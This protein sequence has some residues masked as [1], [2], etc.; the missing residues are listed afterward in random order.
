MKLLSFCD[1]RNCLLVSKK[2]HD[3]FIEY[4]NVTDFNNELLRIVNGSF[5][6]K[7]YISTNSIKLFVKNQTSSPNLLLR[8]VCKF[9]TVTSPNNNGY[10]DAVKPL[11]ED[12]RVDPTC[13]NNYAIKESSAK[14]HS[15]LVELLLEDPRI[16]PSANNNKAIIEA[17][18]N[19][20]FS[21]V[22]LL[23]Q[24]PRVDPSY[25]K[26]YTFKMAV[27]G[28]YYNIMRILL[29]DPRIDPSIGENYAIEIACSDG[30]FDFVQQLLKDPRVI[31]TQHAIFSAILYKYFEIA[32]FLLKDPRAQENSYEFN[33]AIH[34]AQNSGDEELVNL[35]I[36]RNKKN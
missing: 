27:L 13:Y 3:Y 2:F 6:P 35:L 19:G 18:S 23:L 20:H 11:L 28:R 5:E 21:V 30:R 33:I 22:E 4:S 31:P 36:S 17:C 10:I 16:D 8:Y 24:D 32:K 26:S 25:N 7:Y 14:G 34:M 15:A 12:L 1:N 29:Q 9:G